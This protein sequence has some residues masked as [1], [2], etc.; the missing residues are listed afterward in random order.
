LLAARIHFA[1]FG[2][3]ERK[4]IAISGAVDRLYDVDLA[5]IETLAMVYA[6]FKSNSLTVVWPIVVVAQ[7]QSRPSAAADWRML[8]IEDEKARV[9][10]LLGGNTNRPAASAGI[11]LI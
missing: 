3:V 5:F 9:V 7:P 1:A 8:Y 2:C 4:L 11:I 10:L 6:R